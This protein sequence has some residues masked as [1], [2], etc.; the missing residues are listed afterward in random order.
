MVHST[1]F[2][3]QSV[4]AAETT[5]VARQIKPR[6]IVATIALAVALVSNP[7]STVTA[8]Q[9]VAYSASA[10]LENYLYVYGGLTN[11]SSTTSYT[12]Q[13]L[14][15]PLND[16]FD[17]D[18][19]PWEY[20]TEGSSAL[21]VATA[22]AFGSHSGDYNRFIIT[23][24]R[25]NIGR[26]PAIIYDTDK[27]I[28]SQATDLPEGAVTTTGSRMQD[29]RCES[30]GVALDKRTGMLIEFGGRNATAIT[31]EISLLDTNKP[32]DKMTWSYNGFLDAVPPL[33]APILTHLPMQNMTV[34][35]GG[36]DQIGEDGV[37]T[38]CASFDTLYTLSSDSV[39]S[40][41]PKA[42]RVNVT[43]TMFPPPRV[44]TCTVIRNNN[45]LMFG[46]GDPLRP[47]GDAW[48]LHTK[49]W[50]WTQE[51]MSGFPVKG[52]MGH[53]C[54]IANYDQVLVVG[55]TFLLQV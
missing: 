48:M 44:F 29:Y 41:A 13:F 24:N 39:R 1:H 30:P 2:S 17:T 45:I 38:H 19:I 14:T 21:S 28:W 31:N 27:Q 42:T 55:G 3:L 37:P 33:Y 18:N 25:N 34:I 12:S 26:S 32:S 43:G 22:M 9:P 20:H 6:S 7:A 51:S 50:T 47:L 53:S 35:M 23:G 10:V 36:C 49:N 16:E 40:A 46:G 11:F 4:P 54:H 15:L 5:P 52:I 8:Y